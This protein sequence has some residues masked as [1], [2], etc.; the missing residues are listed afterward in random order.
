MRPLNIR[1]GVGL[2]GRYY[3][4][5]NCDGVRISCKTRIDYNKKATKELFR[6]IKRN[7]HFKQE[8]K[9]GKYSYNTEK[10]I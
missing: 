6:H 10:A 1:G 4:D 8:T 2:S 5:R 7:Q 9:N 3:Y